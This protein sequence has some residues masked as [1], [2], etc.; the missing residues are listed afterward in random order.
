MGMALAIGYNNV[1]TCGI[2]SNNS[3]NRIK[4]KYMMGFRRVNGGITLEH[5]GMCMPPKQ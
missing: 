2:H 4:N 1:C 3:I 5:A